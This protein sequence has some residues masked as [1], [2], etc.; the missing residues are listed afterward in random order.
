MTTLRRFALPLCILCTLGARAGTPTADELVARNL[1]ARG[2]AEKLAAIR[3]VRFKGEMSF[4]GGFRMG[5]SQLIARPGKMRAEKFLQ[6]LTQIS[7][8]DG[9]EG[10]RVNP[11]GGRKDPDRVGADEAKNMRITADLEGSLIGWREKGSTLAYLGT[12]DV[13]GTQAHKLLVTHKDG[14]LET[15]Y[16]DPDHFLEIRVTTQMTVRGSVEESEVDY[17]E[18]ALVNGVYFPMSIEA[19]AP[20]GQRYAFMHVSQAEANVAVSDADFAFPSAAK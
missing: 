6:G 18:Y 8:W 2:G 3:S 9:Q 12:E 11:F 14:T 10:W 20:G 4:R 19:G 16:L 15:F 7:A 1:A 5:F 13:D 17:G